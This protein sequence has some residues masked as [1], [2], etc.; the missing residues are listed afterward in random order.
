MKNETASY[1]GLPQNI[2]FNVSSKGA[3]RRMHWTH[4][5]PKEIFDKIFCSLN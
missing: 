1:I 4:V 2:F 5:H 3:P